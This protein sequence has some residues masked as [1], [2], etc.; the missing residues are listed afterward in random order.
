[1]YKLGGLR[2]VRHSLLRRATCN[3][4]ETIADCWLVVLNFLMH[5]FYNRFRTPSGTPLNKLMFKF[6]AGP[7]SI[8]SQLPSATQRRFGELLWLVPTLK[9]EFLSL[10]G[11]WVWSSGCTDT[12]VATYL[13]EVVH[14]K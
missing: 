12:A 6:F 8:I 4:F 2:F 3:K 11:E 14:H 5:V 9:P 1:M 7:M 10:I 13:V